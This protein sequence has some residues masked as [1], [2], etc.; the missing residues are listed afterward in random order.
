MNAG[1][2][3]QNALTRAAVTDPV[4]P[5]P[6]S[7]YGNADGSGDVEHT[8][9]G[10]GGRTIKSHGTL[11]TLTQED[12]WARLCKR[13]RNLLKRTKFL[14]SRADVAS[15]MAAGGDLENNSTLTSETAQLY[16]RLMGDA[17]SS[18]LSLEDI[19]EAVPASLSS[20]E[21]KPKHHIRFDSRSHL[22]VHN[23]GNRDFVPSS[24]ASVSDPIARTTPE[25]VAKPIAEAVIAQP[26]PEVVAQPSL[27]EAVQQPSVRPSEATVRPSEA[28]VQPSEATVQSSEATVH[29]SEATVRPTPA[30]AAAVAATVITPPEW[31]DRSF[32]RTSSYSEVCG[33]FALDELSPPPERHARVVPVVHVAEPQVPQFNTAWAD[34]RFW[35]PSNYLDVCE[36]LLPADL[37]SVNHGVGMPEQ[38]QSP[39]LESSGTFV[40]TV[41]LKA[42]HVRLNVLAYVFLNFAASQDELAALNNQDTVVTK[43]LRMLCHQLGFRKSVLCCVCPYRPLVPFIASVLQHRISADPV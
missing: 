38:K 41:F 17:T 12:H 6:N 37:S 40:G 7:H 28:T 33:E 2:T 35:R 26:T 1:L 10:N 29:P 15:M 18:A 24:A 13:Q 27:E 32:W 31:S 25:A 34:H 39:E 14:L 20:L 21:R 11:S 16:L 9:R 43:R 23:N 42:L 30:A 5:A 4:T 3:P 36:D 22:T 19:M 8:L